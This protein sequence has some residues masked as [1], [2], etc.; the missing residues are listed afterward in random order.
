M[1]QKASPLP[2]CPTSFLIMSLT[3]SNNK[4]PRPDMPTLVWC[5]HQQGQRQ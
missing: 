3:E 2:L 4:K 5:C 1:L